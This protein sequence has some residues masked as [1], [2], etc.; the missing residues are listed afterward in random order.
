MPR[1]LDLATRLSRLSR[2]SGRSGRSRLSRLSGLSGRSGRSGLSRLAGPCR[3]ATG[4]L[5]TGRLATV[6]LAVVSALFAAVSTIPATPAAAW[7]GAIATV[8]GQ[9]VVRNPGAPSAG[10]ATLQLDELWRL[11][12]EESDVLLGIV[13]ELLVDDAGHV[14]L[15]DSQLSEIQVIGPDGEWLNTIGRE[16]EGPGE[17]RNAA[18]MFWAPTGQLGV[19]QSWPGKIVM[20]TPDGMPGD[21]YALPYKKGGNMQ[22]ASRGAGQPG[23][24]VLAG[25]AW[26][27][28]DGDQQQLAYLKAFDAAG[29]EVASFHEAARPM[30]FGNWEF[31]EQRFVDFQRRWAAAPDG[32]VAAAL[33]FDAYRIHVWNA[34]GTLDR[35]I[36]RPGHVLVER[37]AAEREITQTIYD[38]I[39]R[40]NPG[41]TFKIAATHQAVESLHFGQDGSLWVQT[42][43]DVYRNPEDRFTSFD[44]H[45]REGRFVQR[46]H[47]DLDADATTDGIFL[48]GGRL[49]VVTDLR[50]AWL[51]AL[52]AGDAMSGDAEP[53]TVIAYAVRPDTP[54]LALAP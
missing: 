13:S 8:D 29:E 5:A 28:A 32:R 51:S 7:D 19:L 24:I 35:I 53:V 46:V 38:R 40:W 1:L 22:S 39:T 34:D 2:L 25:S 49:Y 48:A 43:A 30:N 4:D 14:Y 47:V 54:A 45:D 12:D 18:D 50:A 21:T 41:S 33:E 15:L 11:G 17:F 27:S 31:Q 42:A 52:D 44:V 37:T 23:R 16:G 36:E 6:T 10:E 26:T 20:I 9:T 3:T